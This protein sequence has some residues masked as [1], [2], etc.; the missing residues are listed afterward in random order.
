MRT[1]GTFEAKMHLSVLLEQV[2]RGEEIVITR[3]CKAVAG[4]APVAEVSR[5][6]LVDT[7]TRLKAFRRGRRLGDLSVKTLIEEGRRQACA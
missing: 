1:V 3:H 5:D 2:R 6:R 4:L 7:A